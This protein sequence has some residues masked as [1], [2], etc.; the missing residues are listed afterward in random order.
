MDYL[1]EY[2]L[3]LDR[4]LVA[5]GSDHLTMLRLERLF[6]RLM[7]RRGDGFMWRKLERRVMAWKNFLESNHYYMGMACYGLLAL[8]FACLLGQALL[9]KRAESVPHHCALHPRMPS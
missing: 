6:I 5:F 2:A 9:L 7:R 1:E 3:S 4:V 8:E